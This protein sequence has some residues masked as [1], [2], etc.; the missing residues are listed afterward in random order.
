MLIT[1]I[2]ITI[3]VRG[4]VYERK[5]KRAVFIIIRSP[6]FGHYLS[7]Q[8]PRPETRDK[9]QQ[10]LG[11][12]GGSTACYRQSYKDKRQGNPRRTCPRPW[13]T[14]T[15]QYKQILETDS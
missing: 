12:R 6:S 3:V 7:F 10:Q 1:K 13:A 14:E 11:K 8:T 5:L 2:V 15:H 4:N 9:R